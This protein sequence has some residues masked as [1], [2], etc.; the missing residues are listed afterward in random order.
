MWITVRNR[1]IVMSLDGATAWIS[2]AGHRNA[3]DRK[4][5]RADALDLAPMT[6]G[7]TETNDIAHGSALLWWRWGVVVVLTLGAARR[8]LRGSS[9]MR[10]RVIVGDQFPD[11][12]RAV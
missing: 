1:A 10:G 8:R 2:D 12:R 6:R 4:M 9:G 5:R 3:I 7:I 11:S